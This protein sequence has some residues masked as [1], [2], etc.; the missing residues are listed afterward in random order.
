MLRDVYPGSRLRRRRFSALYAFGDSLSDAGNTF[1]AT[2][3]ATPPAPPNASVN[4]Y[5]VFSN[6]P[7]WVQ[8]LASNLGLSPLLPSLAGETDFAVGGA[9]T[10]AFGV[11]NGAPGDLL[12]ALAIRSLPRSFACS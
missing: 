6:G 7:V 2:G 4:G 3:G 10:G 9:Q 1:I 11:Y 12:P 5:G 8:D